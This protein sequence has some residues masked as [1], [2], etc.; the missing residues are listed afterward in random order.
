MS[1]QTSSAEQFERLR[2]VERAVLRLADQGLSSAEIAWR[3]RRSPGHIDRMLELSRH[4]RSAPSDD[5]AKP[6]LRPV[7]RTV[8]KARRDGTSHA[9]LAAR[10]RRTPEYVARVE[11]FAGFKLDGPESWRLMPGI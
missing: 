9:E 5:E 4:P 11:R 7:E 6:V 1:V 10:L 8:L 2:P 3:F